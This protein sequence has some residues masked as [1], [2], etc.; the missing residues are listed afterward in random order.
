M[1]GLPQRLDL[2]GVAALDHVNSNEW[3]RHSPPVS[4][5]AVTPSGGPYTLAEPPAIGPWYWPVI[6]RRLQSRLVASWSHP[7]S[8][9][10]TAGSRRSAIA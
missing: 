9:Q 6:P 1:G 8:Q 5:S 4:S 10:V 7:Q 3:D 2:V